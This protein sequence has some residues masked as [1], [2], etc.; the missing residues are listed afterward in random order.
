MREF[1]VHS[2]RARDNLQ[3]PILRCGSVNGDVGGDVLDATDVVVGWGVEVC[4]EAISEGEFVV[5]LIFEKEHFLHG[6]R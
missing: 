4:L 2:V 5:N 3:T 6:V 1:D